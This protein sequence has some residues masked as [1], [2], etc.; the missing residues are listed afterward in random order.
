MSRL[1]CARTHVRWREVTNTQFVVSALPEDIADAVCHAQ[2]KSYSGDELLRLLTSV[3]GLRAMTQRAFWEAL[4][5]KMTVC[6]QQVIEFAKLVPGF[7]KLSQDD[8]IMVLK[9]G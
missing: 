6:I 7:T 5:E 4:S 1:H 8:Q 2:R 9:G 3:E